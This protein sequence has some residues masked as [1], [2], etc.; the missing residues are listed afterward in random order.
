MN[1]NNVRKLFEVHVVLVKSIY[2]SNIGATARAMT[3]MGAQN[4]ILISP[5]CEVDYSAQQAAASGQ[6]PLQNRK[7]YAT[8]D[9][10][11]NTEPEG[12]R[13]A[14]TARDGRGRA[15]QDLA[16]TLQWL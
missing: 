11:F 8:W 16:T 14:L 10:F 5:Q 15:V 1:K 2:P 3:N 12:I 4:L 6:D 13:L 9:D 7:V